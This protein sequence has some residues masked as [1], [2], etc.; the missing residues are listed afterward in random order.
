MIVIVAI[1]HPIAFVLQKPCERA[2]DL[3]ERT[4]PSSSLVL[5]NRLSR[6]VG[7]SGGKNRC[8]RSQAPSSSLTAFLTLTGDGLVGVQS[9]AS[10]SGISSTLIGDPCVVGAGAD[11]AKE[12]RPN[13]G[14]TEGMSGLEESVREERRSGS[15]LTGTVGMGEARAL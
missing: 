13:I 12:G 8:G 14:L 10:S 11:D 5:A 1:D 2:F 7:C 15:L 6:P 4:P 9:M 3:A